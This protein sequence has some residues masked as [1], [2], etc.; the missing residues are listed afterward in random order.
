MACLRKPP[1]ITRFPTLPKCRSRSKSIPLKPQ[2]L[3]DNLPHPAGEF[4]QAA[5]LK[6]SA[7]GGVQMSMSIARSAFPLVAAAS[8]LCSC[9]SFDTASTNESQAA[10]AQTDFDSFFDRTTDYDDLYDHYRMEGYSEKKARSYASD[11]AFFSN[12]DPPAPVLY[13]P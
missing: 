5:H 11:E 10:T 12:L 9:S 2:R 4:V 1:I 3:T 8:L 6:E 13:P 7:R